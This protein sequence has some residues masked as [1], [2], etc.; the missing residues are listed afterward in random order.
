MLKKFMLG[1]AVS[2]LALSGAFAQSSSSP[3][4]GSTSPAMKSDSAKPAPTGSS[5]AAAPASTASASGSVVAKQQPDQ[6]LA[7]KFKGTDVVGSDDK[8]IGDVSDILFDKDGKIEAYVVGVGG[9]LGMG[10]KEVALP[11]SSFEVIKGTNGNAD[12]L[13][14]A[15]SKDDLKTAQNFEP[16]QPPRPVTTTGSRPGGLGGAPSSNTAPH[17]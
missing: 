17:K 5:S 2:A 13:K 12:K 14:L 7:S 11:P 3:P 15:M 1:A 9:F 16:Y 4:S 6:F 10:A 8:K